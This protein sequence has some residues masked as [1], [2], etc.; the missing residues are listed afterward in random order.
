[1][2]QLEIRQNATNALGTFPIDRVPSDGINLS[3]LTGFVL[4]RSYPKGKQRE[5]EID[6]DQV[7]RASVLV[8]RTRLSAFRAVCFPDFRDRKGRHRIGSSGSFG[9]RHSNRYWSNPNGAIRCQRRVFAS[10]PPA[11]AVSDGS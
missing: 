2:E 8:V 10:R 6:L 9:Y 11:R 5:Y 7:V 3:N 4:T 1:M